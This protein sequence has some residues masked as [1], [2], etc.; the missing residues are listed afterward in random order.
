MKLILTICL[1]AGFSATG[2][3]QTKRIAHR[4][5][6]GNNGSFSIAGV[7]NFGLTPEMEEER[8]RKEKLQKAK[9][10]SLMTKAVADSIAKM[11]PPPKD[12]IKSKSKK[13]KKSSN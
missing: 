5:H 11:N 6:S 1:L 7:H 12:K 13:K 8:K 9:A 10:D 4:S 2:F 3:S